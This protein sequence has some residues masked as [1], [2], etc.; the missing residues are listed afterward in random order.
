VTPPSA[1]WHGTGPFESVAVVPETVKSK[2]HPALVIRVISC[3]PITVNCS[4]AHVMSVLAGE[5]V[6]HVSVAVWVPVQTPPVQ[7]S[8][9]LASV[10][11]VA[12]SLGPPLPQ[13]GADTI[14]P[15]GS[16]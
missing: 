16:R 3:G 11:S 14:S 1:D 4:D 2:T 6:E 10:A 5:P 13:V 12:A 8:N 7:A 9:E 15:E